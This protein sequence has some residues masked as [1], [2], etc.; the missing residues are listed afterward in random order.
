MLHIYLTNFIVEDKR[1]HM[2]KN[3]FPIFIYNVKLL[4]FLLVCNILET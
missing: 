2:N 3:F 1:N 4:S